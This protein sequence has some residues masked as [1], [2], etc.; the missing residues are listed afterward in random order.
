MP[1]WA[2]GEILEAERT[3]FFLHIQKYGL[4]L[5]W[6]TSVRSTGVRK[7]FNSFSLYPIQHTVPIYA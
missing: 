1:S 2:L 4:W 7:W 3:E 6:R 5:S